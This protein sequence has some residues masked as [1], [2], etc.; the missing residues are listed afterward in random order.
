MAKQPKE[1]PVE[2]AVTTAP[3]NSGELSVPKPTKA[4]N[5]PAASK[6]LGDLKAG[7]LASHR[8]CIDA[9]QSTVLH[10]ANAGRQL[11][12][13]QAL[14]GHGSWTKWIEENFTSETGLQKKT[15][16]RYMSVAKN[17]QAI[18]DAVR[19]ERSGAMEDANLVSDQDLL[20]ELSLSHAYRLAAALSRPAGA[21]SQSPAPVQPGVDW[22][23]PEPIIGCAKR[24]V[25]EIDSDPCA[26]EVANVPAKLRY[27]KD[28]DGLRPEADWGRTAFVSPGH[29]PDTVRFVERTVA[30]FRNQELSEA[31]L[32]LPLLADSPWVDSLAAFPRAIL[33]RSLNVAST[34]SGKAMKLKFPV[35]IVFLAPKDR[36][37]NFAEVFSEIG[38]VYVPHVNKSQIAD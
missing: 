13:A 6:S 28:D 4:A 3:V 33:R 21:S 15:A 27:R 11:L 36:F 34:G 37:A 7:I 35:E 18:L 24:V 17:L 9:M 26:A 30:L 23:T 5:R 22:L 19:S 14:I 16:E 29:S 12:A 2:A 31:V 38:H 8:L 32:L 1:K 10:A 20:G 25:V